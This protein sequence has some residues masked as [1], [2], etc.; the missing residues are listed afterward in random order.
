MDTVIYILGLVAIVAA[1]VW[2]RSFR[3]RE[4]LAQRFAKRPSMSAAEFHKQFYFGKLD[5]ATV[6]GLLNNVAQEYSVPADKL[7]PTDRF[8]VELKQP[9]GHEFDAGVG[10]LPMQ[11]EM[12]A[13]AKG[14]MLKAAN[15]ETVDDYITSM[16]RFS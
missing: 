14:S 13:R 8:D 5:L 9:S 3:Q 1:L 6:Q 11:V 4:T 16:A 15:I 10:M 12:A 7:L 2:Y